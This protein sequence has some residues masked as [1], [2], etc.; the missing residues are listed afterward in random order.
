MGS[1]NSLENIFE[2]KVDKNNFFHLKQEE[3][4]KLI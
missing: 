3:I 2:Y 4:E 1:S